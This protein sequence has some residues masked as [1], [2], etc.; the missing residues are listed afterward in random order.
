MSAVDVAVTRRA[1]QIKTLRRSISNLEK[2]VTQGTFAEQGSYLR[3]HADW[4]REQIESTNAEIDRLGSLSD[5]E[6]I[7]SFCPEVAQEKVLQ[8]AMERGEVATDIR[9]VLARGARAP[10]QVVVSRHPLPVR[11][12]GGSVGTPWGSIVQTP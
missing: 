2:Q 12:E 10:E 8:R 11:R 9:D 7:A 4:C 1:D 3:K 5:D 6:L